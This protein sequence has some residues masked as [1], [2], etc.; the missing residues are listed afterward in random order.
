[1]TTS[2]VRSE[3]AHAAAGVLSAVVALA[4]AELAA[5]LVSPT[6]SPV[7][8]VG[9][10][11]VDSA[12]VWLKSFAINTFG[13]H[14]KQVLVGGV[15]VV[16]ALY[17]AVVGVLAFLRPR[18]G[19]LGIVLFAAMGAAAA[20]TRPD[21][22]L[23]AVLPSVLGGLAGAVALRML[24]RS[25]RPAVTPASPTIG[26]A[27]ADRRTV[28]L[29]A[30]GLGAVAAVSGATGRRLLSTRGDVD[31]S[32]A[33]LR[34]PAPADAA[35]A[36]PAGTDLGVP[37]VTPFL[38]PAKDFYRVD[39]ALVLPRVNPDTWRLTVKGRV[40]RPF[41]LS[42][43]ELLAMPMVERVLTMTC[44]SNEVGGEYAG[45]ARWLGVPLAA[46]LDRAGIDP[47]ADQIVMRSADG[48]TC[49]TPTSVALDG[50][51]SLLAVG[52]NGEPL[53][54]AHGFPVRAVVPGLYGYV[55]GCKWLTSLE[56]TTFADVDTYWIRRGWGERGP[57]KTMAR[58]DTPGSFAGLKPGRRAV[59][60][61]AWAQHRGVGT[62]EVRVDG[63]PWSAA[64]LASVPS[65]DTWRQW[66]WEWDA[67]P[68]R[69]TLEARATDATGA[70]QTETRTP[71]F[72]DGATGWHSRVVTVR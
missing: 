35:P 68:G 59:A 37:G 58:I 56:L 17:A 1:M 53:P 24:V 36:L 8:A 39:T 55:S 26:T 38:T 61:V 3:A 60:G 34:L 44:V 19:D 49:G 47:A 2:R 9:G 57:V 28:L 63:G 51:D 7:V 16:L 67:T 12:P 31:A 54:I 70:Q 71:P 48:W 27:T 50:R 45:N 10:V 42:F 66:I 64:R 25:A 15:L 40:S 33:A 32:R 69:H 65:S 18:I 6:S 30:A 72:P 52:M 62:V 5:A 4:V 29:T 20:L 23:L 43:A 41:S 11:A 21:A 46:V 14:D 13:V 22:G